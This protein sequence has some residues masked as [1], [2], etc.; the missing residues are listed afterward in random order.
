MRRADTGPRGRSPPGRWAPVR[1]ARPVFSL[2]GRSVNHHCRVRHGLAL[3]IEHMPDDG[4]P[5]RGR[6]RGEVIGLCRDQSLSR[7][8]RPGG[9]IG[10]RMR[11][12]EEAGA[13]CDNS[14]EQN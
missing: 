12:C 7:R 5:A 10:Y 3:R 2:L 13:A 11:A 14:E 9:L 4:H 6:S 1:C 8:G